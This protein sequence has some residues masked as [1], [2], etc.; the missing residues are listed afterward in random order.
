MWKK[1]TKYLNTRQSPSY[2]YLYMV[3]M[4]TRAVGQAVVELRLKLERDVVKIILVKVK[5]Q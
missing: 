2:Y 3:V 5:L 4:F 1:I